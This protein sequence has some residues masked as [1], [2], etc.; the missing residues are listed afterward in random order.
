[1]NNPEFVATSWVLRQ[2]PER[3][4]CATNAGV[5]T[6]FVSPLG[7]EYYKHSAI[8][9]STNTDDDT[10]GVIIAFVR[11]ASNV[12]HV[13]AA[14]R[15]HGGN[16]PAL[17]WGLV[18]Y[19]DGA[20]FKV[21]NNID[22]GGVN[23]NGTSGDKLGWNS[24]MSKI[25]VVREG[26]K[27]TAQASPW[28]LTEGSLAVSSASKIEIDLSNATLGL[29]IFQGAKPYGYM[30]LSQLGSEYRAVDFSTGT[31]E[32]YVYDLVNK[33]VY[34]KQA[35]GKYAERKDL[36]AFTHI[37]TP[38]K[39]GNPDTGSIFQLDSSKTYKQLK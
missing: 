8:V 21:I 39:V 15:T 14:V 4:F 38:R 25:S 26:N 32:T 35:S 1:V 29:S 3:I 19:K 34:E 33:I 13:L 17:G 18:Y 24:R 9:M 11:D 10:I 6:G 5:V 12:N 31:N 23:K 28:G 2:L 36:D 7:F 30:T 16:A 22:V 37:G 27:I 20:V